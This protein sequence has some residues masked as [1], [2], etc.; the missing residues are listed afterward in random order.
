MNLQC[1]YPALGG[2]TNATLHEVFFAATIV[3]NAFST[4]AIA[5]RFAMHRRALRGLG[6]A[7]TEYT[8]VAGVLAESAALYALVGTV[9]LPLYV[10]QLP[11]A[12]AVSSVFGALSVCVDLRDVVWWC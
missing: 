10:L 2:P 1:A 8:T 9:Y 7:A 11:A 6:L 3:C 4:A 5:A 12:S